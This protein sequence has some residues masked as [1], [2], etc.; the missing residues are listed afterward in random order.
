MKVIARDPVCGMT[1][2]PGSAAA[3]REHGGN[4]YLFCAP[5]CAAL[6][7]RDPQKYLT[8]RQSTSDG[9][10]M[11]RRQRSLPNFEP[12]PRA[13]IQSLKAHPSPRSEMRSSQNRVRNSSSTLSLAIEGMHCASCVTT[14]EN[15]L[16]AVPGVEK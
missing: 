15:A 16:A 5:G 1:V 9:R 12:G 2:D 4:M 13:E 10:P 3:T 8:T 11:G 7:D 14:I 6:F